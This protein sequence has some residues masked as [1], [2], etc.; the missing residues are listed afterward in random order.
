MTHDDLTLRAIKLHT[1][2]VPGAQQPAANQSGPAT[3]G[4]LAYVVLR[5]VSGVLAVYRVLPISRTLKRL[6][7]W[8][9][10][11]NDQSGPNGSGAQA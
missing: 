3:V 5:N 7:R 11:L 1:G 10:V 4:G 6:K 8:P 9:A 2:R